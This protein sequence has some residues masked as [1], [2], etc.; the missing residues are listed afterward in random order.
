MEDNRSGVFLIRDQAQRIVAVW[1]SVW[2]IDRQL[3]SDQG[4]TKYRVQVQR[5][6]SGVPVVCPK[7]HGHGNYLNF[8]MLRRFEAETGLACQ[9]VE[10]ALLETMAESEHGKQWVGLTIKQRLKLLDA[11]VCLYTR[12]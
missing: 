7:I 4:P 5:T 11:V 8:T 12:N 9:S 1:S 3:Q 10:R 2:M 6:R